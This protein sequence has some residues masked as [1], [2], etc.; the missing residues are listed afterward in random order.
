LRSG[1]L[2]VAK[3]LN[4]TLAFALELAVRCGPGPPASLSGTAPPRGALPSVQPPAPPDSRSAHR[5]AP[6][7]CRGAPPRDPAR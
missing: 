4:A 3:A 1:V 2:T 7:L 6:D 5:S